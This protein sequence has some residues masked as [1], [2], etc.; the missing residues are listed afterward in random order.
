VK[1]WTLARVPH[2]V[3]VLRQ[4]PPRP[5]V[6]PAHYARQACPD[7]APVISV[8]TPSFNQA[9]FLERTLRSV[10]DQNYPALE[11]IVQDGGSTDGSVELLRR[12]A[13]RL[14]R[15][16]SGPDGGQADAINRGFRHAAGEILAYLNSDDLL[17]PGSLAYVASYFA[18]HPEADVVYGHRVV[19]DEDDRETAR[20][21]LP[22]HDDDFLAWDDYVPQET[23]FWRRR[24]WERVGARMDDRFQFALD[25]DLLLRFRE[26]GARFAR[27]PRFAGAF[28]SH[29][30]QKTVTRLYDYYY[31][32]VRRLRERSHGRPVTLSDILQARGP[33]LLRQGVYQKLYELGLLRC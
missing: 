29:P 16:E 28:R 33:Y 26:S 22:P 10:L 17:L 1:N 6:L 18:R 2:Q 27:L 15:W 4:Y 19:V 21:V 8:V 25:W 20:W 24:A 5:L 23:M 31:P 12:Y 11:Y 30:E 32:E 14:K 3:G 7:P 13:G 9:V